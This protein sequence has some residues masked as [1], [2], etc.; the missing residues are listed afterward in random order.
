MTGSEVLFALRGGAEV[1][2]AAM[3]SGWAR[4]VDERGRSGWM[5]SKYLD[6]Q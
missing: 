4:V 5:Y 1:T 3:Q 6:R 2:I